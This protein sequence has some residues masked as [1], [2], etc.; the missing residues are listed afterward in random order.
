MISLCFF[1]A[2]TSIYTQKKR[3]YHTILLSMVFG[4][5]LVDK[6]CDKPAP[7]ARSQS[8]LFFST[9][10]KVAKLLERKNKLFLL[11]QLYVCISFNRFI[12]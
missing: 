2:L 5:T 11:F 1:S 8:A 9:N 6:T 3:G 7:Y 12:P 10:Y 4:V